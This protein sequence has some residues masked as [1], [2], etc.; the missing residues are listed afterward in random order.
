M[1]KETR[2]K[3]EKILVDRSKN[4]ESIREFDELFFRFSR[5]ILKDSVME[6]SSALE[7][8]TGEFLKIFKD[9]PFEFNNSRY[10]TM[11]ILNSRTNNRLIEFHTNE[12]NPSLKFEGKEING[13]VV[14]SQRLIDDNRFKE[15]GVF[16][17]IELT[18]EK[19]TELLVNFVENVFK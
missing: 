1:K 17:I 14:V 12:A 10:F 6:I 11:V 3:L 2:E 13:R 9:D 8:A 19:T 15:V 4:I 7:R 5:R 16:P 18:E